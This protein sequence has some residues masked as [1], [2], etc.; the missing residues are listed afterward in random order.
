MFVSYVI[1]NLDDQGD[2]EILG[3]ADT[4]QSA[5][6]ILN[7]TVKNED[8]IL[9][10]YNDWDNSK[11]SDYRLNEEYTREYGYQKSPYVRS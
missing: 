5:I 8:D 1:R 4:P 7:N 6:D 2:L 9:E 10:A 3:C 11:S